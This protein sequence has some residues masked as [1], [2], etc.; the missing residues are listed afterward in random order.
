M[1]KIIGV[2]DIMPGGLLHGSNSPFISDQVLAYLNQGDIRVGT[3]ECAIGNSPDFIEEKMS[4]YGDVIYAPDEDLKRLKEMNINLVSLA[5]NH[6][7]DLKASGAL[8]TIE[9]LN[10]LGIA[11]CGAG[12]NLQEAQKPVVVNINGKNIAFLAF[13]DYH[14]Y[15]GYIPFA[16]ETTPGVNPMYDDY[17]LEQ[18]ASAKQKY[19]YVV[20]MPHWGKEHRFDPLVWCY[21]MANKMLKAGAD[22]IL[23]GHT[24]RVQS[25]VNT[26]GKSIAYSMGN[27]CFPSRLIAPPLRATYYPGEPLSIKDLPI[28]DRYPVVDTITYKVWKPLA[29]YGMVVCASVDGSKTHADY[30]LTHLSDE[31]YIDFVGQEV[32]KVVTTNLRKYH[33]IL[34]YLPYL[35]YVRVRDKCNMYMKKSSNQ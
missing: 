10:A 19:D 12:K 16:T 6:F 14:K 26:K 7:F 27:F 28:T 13:C 20:V 2:G 17:A 11:H 15:I 25:V 21:E 34:K 32:D 35:L 22:L 4:K 24:H 30:M 1:I 23:G 3:L 5:N 29:K 18:I 33:F 9:M 31:N 8:H